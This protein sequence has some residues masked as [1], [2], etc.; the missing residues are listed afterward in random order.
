[1]IDLQLRARRLDDRVIQSQKFLEDDEFIKSFEFKRF[2]YKVKQNELTLN[3]KPRED[4]EKTKELVERLLA[5]DLDSE[6]VTPTKARDLVERSGMLIVPGWD[7]KR[8]FMLDKI[9]R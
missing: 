6:I 9:R 4:Q 8:E 2:L 7:I 1:M 5:Y 3:I